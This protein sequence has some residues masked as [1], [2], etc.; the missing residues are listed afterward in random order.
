MLRNMTVALGEHK[1]KERCL[2]TAFSSKENS[3]I[4]C[5]GTL[6]GLERES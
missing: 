3:V 5:G 2:G 4:H 1:E 6:W